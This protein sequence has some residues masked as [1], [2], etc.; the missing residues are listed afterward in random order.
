M[1]VQLALIDVPLLGFSGHIPMGCLMTE[2][3]IQRKLKAIFSADVKGYSLLMG[4]DD[5][6]TVT[7]I[8][9]YREIIAALIQ[10]HQ[11]R[12]VDSPGDNILAEF[13]STL[14]AVNSAVDIQRK[15]ENE[16]TELPDNRRMDFRIGINLGDILHKDGRI[17]GDSVN[18][19]ARIESL[20]D[21]GGICI[22]RGVYD[23]VKKKVSQG[24]EYLGEH[25]VKNISE[26]V[27][28]YRIL[29]APDSE[30]K[31][32]GE[33]ITKTTRIKMP[34]GAVIAI[35]V[36]ASAALIWMIYPRLIAT[37]PD[38]SENMAFSLPDKPS[39]AVL[40]FANMSEDPEQEYFSDGITNDII[41]ALSKFG[42]LLVI[43]SNTIFTYKDKPV[44]IEHVG[45]ELGVRYVLE[46][47]VQ[48]AGA[49]V[50]INAQLVDA[51][52]G[53]H[54]WSEHYDRELKDIFAVQDEIVQTIVGK[55]AVEIDAAER[56]RVMHKK[57][58]SLEAYDY[59]LRGMEYFR[60]RTRSD[61]RKARQMFEKAIELDPDF[62][63]AYVGLGRTYQIQ[64]PSAGPNS[65]LR[66]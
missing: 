33:S 2:N 58:E 8:T 4:D 37:E 54:I 12:I 63:Y 22:S 34:Y 44:N 57:T 5:E 45:Q 61:N 35:L 32:I 19:A 10:K 36:V 21:P 56:K 59:Q 20:A 15:L 50:R 3:G 65:L 26:P 52:T 49:K 51:V 48:K 53:F 46:G 47:S 25:S 29:L 6:S 39:I 64:F 30:G 55:F 16:N 40:P 14:N 24:F 13:S 43:A 28:T 27:R 62:A 60:R 9:A 38:S 1:T 41:T 42:E 11:G 66:P 31:I 18:V 17:Y 7:T 23:Q